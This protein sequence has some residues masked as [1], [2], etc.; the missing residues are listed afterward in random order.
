[1]LQAPTGDLNSYHSW[2]GEAPG[3]E[4]D[5][6]LV[7]SKPQTRRGALSVLLSCATAIV[8]GSWVLVGATLAGDELRVKIHTSEMTGGSTSPQTGSTQN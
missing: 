6:Q 5:N 7:N 4:I 3:K 2:K 8:P 1:M